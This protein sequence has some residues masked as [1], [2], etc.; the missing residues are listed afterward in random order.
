MVCPSPPRW[1]YVHKRYQKRAHVALCA[2]QPHREPHLQ[3]V[4]VC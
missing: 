2:T 3:Q 4:Q 1:F